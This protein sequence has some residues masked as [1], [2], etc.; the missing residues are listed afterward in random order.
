MSVKFEIG[1]LAI[2][3]SNNL[4]SKTEQ[5]ESPSGSKNNFNLIR[6][7]FSHG[8]LMVYHPFGV[9]CELE[10]GNLRKILANS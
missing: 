6:F 4:K 7:R 10:K 9:I 8:F 2:L 3:E 1:A 5:I